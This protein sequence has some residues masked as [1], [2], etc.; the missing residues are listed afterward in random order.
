MNKY[1]EKEL[2]KLSAEQ[3]FNLGKVGNG[4][5][6]QLQLI[7]DNFPFW[8]HLNNFS[9]LGLIYMNQTGL[10]SFRKTME[11]VETEGGLQF[12]QNVIHPCTAEKVLPLKFNFINT[13][14]EN[15]VIFFEQQI[16]YSLSGDY[17]NHLSFSSLNKKLNATITVTFPADILEEFIRQKIF[18]S[19]FV[20]KNYYEGFLS[21]TKREKEV[22]KYICEGKS[23]KQIGEL[24]SLSPLTV[25]THRKNI[26]NKLRTNKISDFTRIA[27][28]FNLLNEI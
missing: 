12:L 15:R 18:G 10:S 27:V 8:I 20:F 5:G 17:K 25:K 16:R 24:L 4:G 1:S 6:E 13:G 28:Y 11:E 9:D 22:F 2:I 19:S 14:D 21:L 26:I 3:V 23:T 7:A